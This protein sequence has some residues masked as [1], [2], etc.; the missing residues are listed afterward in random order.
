MT[1]RPASSDIW[2]QPENLK[3]IT[4]AL[5]D[6]ARKLGHEA[7]EAANA[8]SLKEGRLRAKWRATR[9]LLNAA[10]GQASGV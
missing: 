9:A 8:S 6:Q 4:D 2:T 3:I 10:K 5:R 1:R 7:R